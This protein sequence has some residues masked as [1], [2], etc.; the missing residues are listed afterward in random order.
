MAMRTRPQAAQD[1]IT[2]PVTQWLKTSDMAKRLSRHPAVLLRMA[3]RGVIPQPARIGKS[4]LWNV[5]AVEAALFA[6]TADR[7]EGCSDV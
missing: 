7:V 3:K 2:A 4:C 1:N 5:Q 6:A